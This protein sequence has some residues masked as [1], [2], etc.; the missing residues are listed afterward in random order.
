[1]STS[2]DSAQLASDRFRL[3]VSPV[4]GADV[5][6]VARNAFGAVDLK[7]FHP[8][9]RHN[10]FAPACLVVEWVTHDGSTSGQIHMITPPSRNRRGRLTSI[11]YSGNYQ[12]RSTTT[13][14]LQPCRAL[15]ASAAA[16]ASHGMRSSS[17]FSA[18][19]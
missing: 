4:C 9:C 5:R 11:Q 16:S 13:T 12:R 19:W 14:T 17:F 10:S 1:M 3:C 15:R 18:A 2:S 8:P 6:T 7:R